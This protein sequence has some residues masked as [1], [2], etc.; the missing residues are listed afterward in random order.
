MHLPATFSVLTQ[1]SPENVTPFLVMYSAIRPRF[2]PSLSGR[3]YTIP[4][5]ACACCSDTFLL[6]G[7]I[8][9]MKNMGSR[10][11]T[12]IPNSSDI[13]PSTVVVVGYVHP[14]HNSKRT[15]ARTHARTHGS[16]HGLKARFS[17]LLILS[18]LNI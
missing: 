18:R 14:H 16:G 17:L 7:F 10:H 9:R 2:L 5:S 8:N 6:I 13:S 15:H 3:P 4:Y 1:C 12:L 11:Y